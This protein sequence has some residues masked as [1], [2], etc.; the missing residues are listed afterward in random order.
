LDDADDALLCQGQEQYYKHCIE[1][2]FVFLFD[3]K[4]KAKVKEQEVKQKIGIPVSGDVIIMGGKERNA[5]DQDQGEQQ[6]VSG[7]DGKLQ[8]ALANGFYKEVN[9]ESEYPEPDQD[10]GVISL[11]ALYQRAEKRKHAQE[12]RP[13][14]YV[15]F[16]F[17]LR[18]K[19]PQRLAERSLL[20]NDDAI[21]RV[22]GQLFAMGW[23]M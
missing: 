3:E 6:P 10:D 2:G 13:E 16:L 18:N 14:Q 4:V 9:P 23:R 22:F 20:Q 8:V 11:A 19:T 5:Q 17:H 15:P 1:Q 7:G 12:Y 21:E